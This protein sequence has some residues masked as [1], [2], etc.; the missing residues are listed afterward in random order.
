VVSG[1][2]LPRLLVKSGSN[3]PLPPGEG[4]GEGIKKV[5]AFDSGAR[6]DISLFIRKKSF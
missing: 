4:W 2:W 5:F 3:P 6:R 1:E